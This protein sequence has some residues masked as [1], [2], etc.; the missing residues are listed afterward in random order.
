MKRFVCA[1]AVIAVGICSVISFGG[2]KEGEAYVEYKLSES[3]D[4]YI[5]SG[6]S[7]DKRGLKSYEVPAEYSAAEGESA[8]PVKEIGYEAFFQCTNLSWV[9]IPDSVE[10]IGERAFAQCRFSKF[11][12][13]EGVKEIRRGA[14]G[15]CEALTEITVPASVEVLAYQAFYCCSSLE[16]AVVKAD[17]TDL[18]AQV[19]YNTVA[20]QGGNVYTNSSLSKVY[21]PATVQKI[22][23]SALYGNFLTDIYFE[24][25]PE[26]WNAVSFYERTLKEGTENEYEEKEVEKSSAL[27][28]GVNFH[29]DEKF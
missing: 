28:G 18:T 21:L 10:I 17:I 20:A 9:T 2:C 15:L 29:Y 1:A 3:G 11:T 12:I 16:K 23:A 4:Y 13:P 8:L 25:T 27:P 24:G 7:G 19:F 5:V 14:F 22:D 6:V 26:Q